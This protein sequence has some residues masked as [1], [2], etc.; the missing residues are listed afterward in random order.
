MG[1]GPG[2]A[3][4]VQHR[5]VGVGQLP[6]EVEPRIR[7]RSQEILELNKCKKGLDPHTKKR[8]KTKTTKNAQNGPEIILA[9][10]FLV[11]KTL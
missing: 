5:D 6:P 4:L 9:I 3:C 10:F 7:D 8:G 2:G 1:V 11:T